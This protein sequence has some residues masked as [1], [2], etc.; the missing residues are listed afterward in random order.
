MKPAAIISFG[1]FVVLAGCDAGQR[2][3]DQAARGTAKSVVTPI[4]E[5]NFPGLPAAQVSDCVIDNAS[6]QEIFEIAKASQLGVTPKTTQ[7]VVDIARR[8]S[9]VECISKV[10]FEGILS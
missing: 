3:V 6:A 9:T 2:V 5:Q 10:A 8:P 1:V 4:V 7:T